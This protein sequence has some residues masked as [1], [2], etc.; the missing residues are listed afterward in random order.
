MIHNRKA[1][2]V[3]QFAPKE[4]QMQSMVLIRSAYGIG[5]VELW[6]LAIIVSGYAKVQVTLDKKTYS[7]VLSHVSNRSRDI[8]MDF[9]KRIYVFCTTLRNDGTFNAICDVDDHKR[10]PFFLF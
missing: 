8:L 9:N 6:R 1:I 10:F 5:L 7:M 4:F 3:K 2:V